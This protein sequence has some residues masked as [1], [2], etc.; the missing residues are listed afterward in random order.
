MKQMVHRQMEE[1][2]HFSEATDNLKHQILGTQPE[3]SVMV[4][5]PTFQVQEQSNTDGR[6]AKPFLFT[7]DDEKSTDDFN[8]A[9][10]LNSSLLK[11]LLYLM[12]KKISRL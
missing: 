2:S 7:L 5:V 11:G 6:I 12:M 3:D 8:Q 9:G 4:S 10:H 1:A